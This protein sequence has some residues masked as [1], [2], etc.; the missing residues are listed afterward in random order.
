MGYLFITNE[1]Y[2]LGI[3]KYCGGG[4]HSQPKTK[5]SRIKMEKCILKY[6][7]PEWLPKLE[8]K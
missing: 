2:Y 5:E 7:W 4:D 3:C 8:K 6:R 1:T